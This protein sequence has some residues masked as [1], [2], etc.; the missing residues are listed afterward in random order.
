MSFEFS[1]FWLGLINNHNILIMFREFLSKE[2]ERFQYD[3]RVKFNFFHGLEPGDINHIFHKSISKYFTKKKFYR[4]TISDELNQKIKMFISKK[5][6]RH[7]RL[8]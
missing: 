5:I 7:I 4:K 8:Q 2:F 6:T 1:L 3:H